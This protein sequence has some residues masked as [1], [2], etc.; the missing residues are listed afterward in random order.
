MKIPRS[1]LATVA[2]LL[3]ASASSAQ[4]DILDANANM[5]KDAATV[6]PT[7]AD[8]VG[9]LNMGHGRLV[10]ITSSDY[11]SIGRGE[12]PANAPKPGE[13]L[14][15]EVAAPDFGAAAVLSSDEIKSILDAHNTLRAKHGAPALTWN[16]ASAKFGDDW[17]QACNFKHSGGKYGENLAAGY[18]NFPAAVKAWYDEVK[19]YNYDAPGFSGKTGHFTQ[20]VWK[21][22]KTVGC[23]KK[24]CPSWTIYICEYDPSGNI[25]TFDNSYFK[26]NVLPPV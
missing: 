15:P 17:L 2:A 6:D 3:V 11:D 9:F 7:L 8:P 1:V 13:E 14:N 10:S 5:N 23:A 26:K 16:P 4:Q 19:D 20:V 18:P 12:W 21:S 24:V 25:V 22:S